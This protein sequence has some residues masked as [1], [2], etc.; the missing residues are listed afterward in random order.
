VDK[1]IVSK[2]VRNQ[3]RIF[4]YETELKRLVRRQL[5]R[6]EPGLVEADGGHER[7]V[8]SGRIDIT[9]QDSNGHWIVIELKAGPCPIGALEQV[10]AYSVDMES[11]TGTPCRAV[12]VAA[13]FSERLRSAAKR[14]REVYLVRYQVEG[15][16]FG[17]EVRGEA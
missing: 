14:A 16:E 2:R 9:A 17:A 7:E 4:H 1:V 12:L 8:A 5:D 3:T 6:V 13:D 10:L 11:E 15:M